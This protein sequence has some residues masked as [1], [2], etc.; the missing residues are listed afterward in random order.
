MTSSWLDVSQD[1]SYLQRRSTGMLECFNA[2]NALLS[3]ALHLRNSRHPQLAASMGLRNIVE[4]LTGEVGLV[5]GNHG[6]R[7]NTKREPP[8]KNLRPSL[9]SISSSSI[10][11]YNNR[12][13]RG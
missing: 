6:F 13:R 4:L 11:R 9:R 2:A 8:A 5:E 7:A 12:L 10:T 3:H 1:G